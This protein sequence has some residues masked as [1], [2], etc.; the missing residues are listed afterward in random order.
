MV[1]ERRHRGSE[2]S[3]EPIVGK[4]PHPY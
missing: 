2:N 1:D 4:L 3:A